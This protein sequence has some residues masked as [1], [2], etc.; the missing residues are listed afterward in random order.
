MRTLMRK[1]S[2]LFF[3]LFLVLPMAACDRDE[4]P[5]EEAAEG[6]EDAVDD[7]GDAIDK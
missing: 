7:I 3:A 5:L 1:M 4:G 6:I 2:P